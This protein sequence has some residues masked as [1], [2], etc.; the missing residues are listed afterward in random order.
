MNGFSS[1]PSDR[2][3]PQA[4]RPPGMALALVAAI[5]LVL[6]LVGALAVAMLLGWPRGDAPDPYSRLNAI[7][8]FAPST[9]AAAAVGRLADTYRPVRLAG[10]SA[11][12]GSAPIPVTEHGPAT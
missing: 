11:G 7:E 2:P 12:S 8:P 4:L 3:R 6:V 5:A 9:K 1:S 10:T